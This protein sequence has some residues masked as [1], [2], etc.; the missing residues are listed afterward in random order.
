[1]RRH[2]SHLITAFFGAQSECE[3]KVPWNLSPSSGVWAAALD[4]QSG[5]SDKNDLSAIPDGCLTEEVFWAS[6]D[7]AA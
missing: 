6:A 1:M 2:R 5:R 3:T 7:V 4:E